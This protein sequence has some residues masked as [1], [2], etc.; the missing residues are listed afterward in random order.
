[1]PHLTTFRSSNGKSYL[2]V[3]VKRAYSFRPGA[4]AEPLADAVPIV[5]EEIYA[6]SMNGDTERLVTD[7]DLF[8]GLKPATDILVRGTAY[9]PEGSGPSF[10]AD[11]RVGPIA[12]SLRIWGDRSIEL[13]KDKEP[14]FSAPKPIRSLPLI[15]DFA[16]GGR[17]E[18]AESRLYAAQGRATLAPKDPRP[19]RL[20]PLTYPR[21]PAGRAF[22]I[23]IDRER[24]VGTPA[25]NIEDPLDPVS[26]DRILAPSTD[27]WID[28]PAAAC[29]E[30][31]DMFTFPR[32]VFFIPAA[33]APPT[34]EL[35]EQRIGFLSLE[36]I[37]RRMA[38][39]DG[40][41][42]PRAFN[43]APLGLAKMR[44]QGG[45]RVALQHLHP[46]HAVL[47]FDLPGDVP[48]L[49]AE[50]QGVQ[51]RELPPHL[52]TVLIEPEQNRVTL[53]WAGLLETAVPYPKE[54]LATMRH[55]A[56]WPA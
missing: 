49:I 5:T 46:K 50:P 19:E 29:F 14:V 39:F 24:I 35:Y 32:A 10:R 56:L 28:C 1:M 8:P 7:V 30:P 53:T 16:Y 37:Q 52:Q 34:R 55:A 47:E 42:D 17:D 45:E 2:C 26:S 21:N 20:G 33:F 13:T 22:F 40:T 31:I 23:D 18:Y 9:A 11:V 27:A 12:K 41:G 6:P 15:W 54:M 38:N 3:T 51:A 48:Q 4:R 36:E 44:L 25:P 43:C